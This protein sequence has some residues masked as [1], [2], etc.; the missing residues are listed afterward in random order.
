MA[1][2]YSGIPSNQRVWRIEQAPDPGDV[3]RVDL[4]KARA[5]VR[6]GDEG[7]IQVET[8]DYDGNRILSLSHGVLTANMAAPL[9]KLHT[10]Y[11]KLGGLYAGG[12]RSPFKY[13][14]LLTRPGATFSPAAAGPFGEL[15]TGVHPHHPEIHQNAWHLGLPFT[16]A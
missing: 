11:G 14:L 13:P 6:R 4:V 2:S 1:D 15:L 7:P 10:H 12:E 5:Y 8:F 9:Y 3:R 16:A